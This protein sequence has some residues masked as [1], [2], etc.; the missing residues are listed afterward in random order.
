MEKFAADLEPI[1]SPG[2]ME[3]PEAATEMKRLAKQAAGFGASEKKIQLELD[4]LSLDEFR[5]W[6]NGLAR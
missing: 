1:Q 6:V 4:R 3:S 5:I 2:G